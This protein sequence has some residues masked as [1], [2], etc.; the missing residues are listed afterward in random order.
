MLQR[1]VPQ[2]CSWHIVAGK[3]S[4]THPRGYSEYYVAWRG[5]TP[6]LYPPSP[7]ISHPLP[8]LKSMQKNGVL[9]KMGL[10]SQSTWG[11]HNWVGL[12]TLGNMG[13][14][15]PLLG[16][17]CR[18][19]SRSYQGHFN[20]N[21]AIILNTNIFLQF[22]YVFCCKGVFDKAALAILWLGSLPT[23]ILGGTVTIHGLEG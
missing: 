20:V 14:G 7:L 1:S 5:D 13:W 17:Y 15:C 22:L 12:L 10:K 9:W 18:V 4:N 8:T 11:T 21:P 16:F 2:G 23:R 6:L 3:P 19:M